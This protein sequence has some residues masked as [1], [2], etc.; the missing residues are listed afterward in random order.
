MY[1]ILVPVVA[2]VFAL[3]VVGKNCFFSWH[4]HDQAWTIS[5]GT[6]FELC[7]HEVQIKLKTWNK[8]GHHSDSTTIICV[9]LNLALSPLIGGVHSIL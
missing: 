6:K 1:A 5:G 2:G 4:K 7:L 3:L 8:V 9:Y